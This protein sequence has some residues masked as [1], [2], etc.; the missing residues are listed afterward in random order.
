[1]YERAAG[2]SS[3][4]TSSTFGM[5]RASRDLAKMIIMRGVASFAVSSIPGTILGYL[6]IQALRRAGI[7]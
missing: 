7:R 1:M 5:P 4:P 6:V 3:Q 2:A